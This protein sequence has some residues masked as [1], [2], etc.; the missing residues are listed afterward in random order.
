MTVAEQWSVISEPISDN[1]GGANNSGVSVTLVCGQRREEMGAIGWDRKQSANPKKTVGD[2]WKARMADAQT[3]ADELNRLEVERMQNAKDAL[4]PVRQQLQQELDAA[5]GLLDKFAQLDFVEIEKNMETIEQLAKIDFA[6]VEAAQAKLEP[7]RDELTKQAETVRTAL[8][9]LRQVDLF[10][11]DKAKQLV[12][13]LSGVEVAQLEDRKAAAMPL[14]DR[15]EAERDKVTAV[16][17]EYDDAVDA[18]IAEFR[19]RDK[20]TKGKLL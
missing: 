18:K 6:S 13:A 9:E 5:N 19:G 15:L 2:V 7:L 17:D 4:A 14:A 8:D 10:R 3:L 16:L 1:A 11:L 20:D 12:E